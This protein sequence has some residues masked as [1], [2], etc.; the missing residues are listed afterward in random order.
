MAEQK[1][2][3]VTQQPTTVAGSPAYKQ[4]TAVTGEEEWQNDIFDCF[5]GEDNL[6]LKGTF[7]PC[8]VFGKTEAR[9]RDPTLAGYERINNDCLFWVGAN[10][11][12]LSWVLTFLKRSE[13]REEYKIKG[14][15]VTDCLFSAFC[16]CCAIIQ[17]EKEIIGKHRQ[18]GISQGYQAP[19]GM[20]V[21]Q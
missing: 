8:F 7:C 3:P 2:A 17:Q 4:F 5:K 10:C 14:D 21:P 20:T 16:Q 18:Q 13:I 1:Q 6:C 15:A 19:A 12:H 11:C 9:R